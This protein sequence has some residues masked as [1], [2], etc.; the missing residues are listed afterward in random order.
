MTGYAFQNVNSTANF[1]IMKGIEN[2]ANIHET[3]LREAERNRN[4]IDPESI[5]RAI[6][7]EYL[8]ATAEERAV[9]D[10]FCMLMSGWTMGTLI[11]KTI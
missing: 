3:F 1:Q 6:L 8:H 2:N 10:T 9:M 5:S 11:N 4:R 7:D